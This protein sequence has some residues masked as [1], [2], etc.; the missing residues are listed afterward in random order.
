MSTIPIGAHE[1]KVLRVFDNMGKT[2]DRYTIV[3]DNG[4]MYSMSDCPYSMRGVCCYMGD[5]WKDAE[6]MEHES[7]LKFGDLPYSVKEHIKFMETG[8]FR[9]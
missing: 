9:K 1:M 2:I 6:P 7:E 4:H 8:I 3:F 5:T